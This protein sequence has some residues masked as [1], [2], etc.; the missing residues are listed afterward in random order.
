MSRYFLSILSLFFGVGGLSV[1]AQSVL[2]GRVELTGHTLPDVSIRLSPGALQTTTDA[3]GRFRF[4]ALAPGT[5]RLDIS[6]ITIQP[7]QREVE[8]NPGET[9]ELILSAQAAERTLQEVTV[10]GLSDFRGIGRLPEAGET[11]INAGKKM[12]IVP[13]ATLDAN[14]TI[15]NARQAFAKVPGTH[16]WESDASGLQINVAT[17]GLSPNR[18]WEYN[19]RQNGY[20]VSSDPFGY[21]EAY[22]NPPLEAVDRLEIIRGSA[23]LQYGPQFGGLLN[24]KLKSAPSD[25]KI[26]VESKQTLGSFGL[27]SS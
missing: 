24:Y 5:Y 21:P 19:V 11:Q 16:V 14:L 1:S 18:S 6:A 12:E 27:F 10:Y 20:D 13:L 17:R 3:N 15:N 4:E 26:S 7:Q 22:Y 25:D 8:I 9:L 2:K 23:S